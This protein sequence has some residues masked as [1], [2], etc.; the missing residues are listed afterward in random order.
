MEEERWCIVGVYING[1]ME[2]KLRGLNEWTEEIKGKGRI[3]VRGDFNA[4]TGKEGGGIEKR[5][6]VN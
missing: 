5:K 3:I 2:R 6:R 1:E 4:R